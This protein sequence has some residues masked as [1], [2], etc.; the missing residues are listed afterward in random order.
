MAVLT[1]VALYSEYRLDDTQ[2]I[3]AL[4]HWLVYLQLIK[5][6][7]PKT[8][9]DD[10]ILFLL[11]LMQVLIGAVIS[12]GD[13]LGIWLFAWAMLAIWVLGQF[14]LQREA[15]RFQQA[16]GMTSRQV[17]R[18]G[19]VDPYAGLFDLPYVVATARVLITTLALGGLIFLTLPR[20]AGATRSQPGAPMTRH[21]TGFDEEVALGQFGEILENDSVV[22]TVDFTDADGKTVDPP[23][24][25]LWRGVTMLLYEKGRWRRQSNGTTQMYV[26]FPERGRPPKLLR[27]RIKLEANDST[28]LF[29]IRPIRDA[30]AGT[31]LPPYLNPIDGTLLRQDPRGGRYDYEVASD[32]DPGGVQPGEERPSFPHTELLLQISEQLKA[33]LRKIAEP[34]IA[35][36]KERE[37]EVS[38]GQASEMSDEQRNQ[39]DTAR[40]EWTVAQRSRPRGLLAR[41]RRVHLQS[42]HGHH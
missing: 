24:E 28:A 18:P 1:L 13:S 5:Y 31:R 22:M 34:A 12:Q 10:W 11:G 40:R 38:A 41:I 3:R 4:G 27:Q 6:F 19:E 7:L 35:S 29:G 42:S 32:L 8:S 25:P 2:L 39:I 30:S 23:I 9:E 17:I 33:R 21:L 14:F 37:P 16:G 20:Q 36:V 26:G 15:G